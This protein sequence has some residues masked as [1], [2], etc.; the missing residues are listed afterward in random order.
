M[1]DN[2]KTYA[3][4][5]IDRIVE[6]KQGNKEVMIYR[7]EDGTWSAECGNP[8]NA[9]LLGEV[10]G[11]FGSTAGE[12]FPTM[13]GALES[14]L[15]QVTASNGVYVVPVPK[16]FASPEGYTGIVS[17]RITAEQIAGETIQATSIEEGSI[18]DIAPGDETAMANQKE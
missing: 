2:K 8:T 16:A 3:Q 5:L 17:G 1:S 4:A 12:A 10:S 11:E 6:F 7:Y 15:A 9:V 14:L 13:E 18:A